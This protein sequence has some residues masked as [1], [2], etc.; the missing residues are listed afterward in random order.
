M[1]VK[2]KVAQNS[3]Q[4]GGGQVSNESVESIIARNKRDAQKLNKKPVGL[5][6][7]SQRRVDETTEINHMVQKRTKSIFG[8]M[9]YI[10][11]EDVKSIFHVDDKT[12]E[13]KMKYEAFMERF[14][15]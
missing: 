11:I 15:K 9:A 12:K 13:E 4:F 1:K 10:I 3:R 2:V 7:M 5:F 6:D 8:K 14:G